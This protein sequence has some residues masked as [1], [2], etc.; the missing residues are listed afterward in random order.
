[1]PCVET[2]PA[3]GL[4]APVLLA[5]ATLLIGG[6]SHVGEPAAPATAPASPTAAAATQR[7]PAGTGQDPAPR[8]AGQA[9]PAAVAARRPTRPARHWDEY[10]LQ[11]A[12]RIVEANPGATY[13]GPVPEPLLAIPV[14]E[15]E[16]N[17]DGSVRSI[18]VKRKP[19]QALDTVELAM[20]AVRRAAPF[21]SVSHLPRP[22]KFTEVFLFD[23]DRKFKPR[24]LDL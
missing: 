2:H 7:A 20:A 15:I 9:A 5:L 6:C 14:L 10:Q 16:L 4:A 18:H 3:R 1:M 23:D 21:G 12:E 19:S 8:Q 17:G 13:A 22:W 11:A 24:T